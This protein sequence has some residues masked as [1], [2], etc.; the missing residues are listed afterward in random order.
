VHVFVNALHRLV[1]VD[2]AVEAEGPD[3]GAAERGE[4]EAAERVAQRVAEAPLERLQPELGVVR[5]LLTLR[6]FDEVRA[7]QSGQVDG[8][9]HFE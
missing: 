9:G 8:H 7:D 6:H 3:R 5:G 1:L 4:Q 2:H